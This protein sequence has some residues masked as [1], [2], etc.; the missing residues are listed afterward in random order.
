MGLVSA[1]GYVASVTL[2]WVIFRPS[3]PIVVL[4]L[5]VVSLI[6]LFAAIL[7]TT[8]QVQ[9]RQEYRRKVGAYAQEEEILWAELTRR[10]E[11]AERE[12]LRTDWPNLDEL[13]EGQYSLK[14]PLRSCGAEATVFRFGAADG[15]MAEYIECSREGHV[16]RDGRLFAN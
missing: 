4:A 8:L 14:C 9:E 1:W 13:D 15:Q 16:G 2:A 10:I 6:G 11:T 12:G 5:G 7:L 3:E